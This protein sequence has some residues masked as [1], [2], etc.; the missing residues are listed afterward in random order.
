MQYI[1]GIEAYD[2]SG[3]SAVTLGKF[4]GLHRGHQKLIDKV[5]KYAGKDVKSIVF[6]FD[7]LPFFKEKGIQKKNLMTNEEKHLHLNGQVDYLIECPFV[8]EIFMMEAEDFIKDILIG[9]FHAKYVVVG[10]DFHFGHNKR[11]DI[12]MLKEYEQIYGYQ[13]DVVEKETYHGREISSTFI[14]EEVEKGNMELVEELLGYPYT[15]IGTVRHGRKLAGKLGF[16]TMNVIPDENKMLPPNGVYTSTV[17]VG[18]RIYPG[19]GNIGC[20]P[21][22]TEEKTTV[23]EN[24]LFDYAE[25]AYGQTIEIGLHA[26]VR[27][28]Q[29]FPS[30]EALSA[31]VEQDIQY[32]KKYFTHA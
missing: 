1:R 20:K 29:K 22:V 24:Y 32:G 8:K 3:A 28:E 4:D 21:T 9:K 31:R 18:D 10:T 5:K 19:I 17:V 7:M 25:D 14:K 16:P 23:V 26:F 2:G 12:H 13:L 11:G 6:S 27:P 30:V 15:I